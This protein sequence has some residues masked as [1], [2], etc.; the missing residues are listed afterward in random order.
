MF[1][2]INQ[3]KPY[4]FSLREIGDNVS[5]DIKLP[6]SWKSESVVGVYK[7][8]TG[9]IQDK[10]DKFNLLSLVSSA[11]KEGYDTVFKCALELITV[12]TEEEE[13]KKLFEQKVKELKE[14]FEQKVNELKLSFQSEPLEKLKGNINEQERITIGQED[15]EGD[16]L[17]GDGKEKRR[18]RSIKA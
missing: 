7:T 11:T 6:L 15:F 14:I 1:E 17:V 13:K 12:N 16:S 9:K 2:E 5:L 18:V 3:L 10:N 8:I 4:F